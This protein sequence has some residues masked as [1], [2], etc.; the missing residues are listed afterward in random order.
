MRPIIPIQP[1][2]KSSSPKPA[3][4]AGVALN[5]SIS[6]NLASDAPD[7]ASAITLTSLPPL[8]LY[9]HVP[10]CVRKCPYCDFNS[11]EL[12]G[13]LPEEQYLAALQADLEQALPLIWGRPIVSI[14]IGGG[15]PSL[16]SASA[17]DRM[18]ALFRACLTVLPGAEITM[19][20]NPGTAEAS[21]FR[22]YAASGINRMSLGIQSFNDT[23]LVSLG[24]IHNAAQACAAIDMAQAA[25]DQV[26]LD[27][28]FALPQQTLQ[29]CDADLRQA[30]S[31][32]TRHLSLYN[33]T[34]E[35][36]TVFAKYP[37]DVPSDDE[38]AAMQDLVADR[39]TQ[40]GFE[41]YE[42][43]AYAKPAYRCFH[44]LNYWEFGDYL[45]IGPGAHSKLSF[46][47]RILRQA[48]LKNPASWM[49]QA[50]R[51][52]GSHLAQSNNVPVADL[53]FEFM[54]NVLRLRDGVSTASFSER[55]GLPV[56]AIGPSI[57]RA[58]RKGL[59]IDDPTRF[60]ATTL[61]WQFLNDLQ[62]EFLD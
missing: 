5:D 11:H 32:G 26:N 51:H 38:A 59:L 15:T 36:N 28:M 16:L 35:P 12:N 56:A 17:M 58:V 4:A 23:A 47:N 27:L 52:D 44:N 62:S 54:L 14:F 29:Q 30:L 49:A 13:D 19:E 41:R 31:F 2:A 22:D 18:L 37:P 1:E 8:S 25:V 60:Q 39:L 45:G 20:A 48:R 57:D 61:G 24:R 9:V 53:P 21:R 7:A 10:W 6:A 42:V 50:V 34:L 3:L 33:L 40:A 46:H 55:T 43:S